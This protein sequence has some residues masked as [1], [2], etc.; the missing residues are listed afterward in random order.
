M[1]NG[2]LA[3]QNGKGKTRAVQE[4]KRADPSTKDRRRGVS[5]E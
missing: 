3:A 1:R 4:M 5:N 2:A